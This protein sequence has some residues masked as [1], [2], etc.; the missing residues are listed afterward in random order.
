M[1]HDPAVEQ[2]RRELFRA[3]QDDEEISG[4]NVVPSKDPRGGVYIP[5]REFARLGGSAPSI[6]PG[7]RSRTEIA[8]LVLLKPSLHRRPHKWTFEW[9]GVPLSAKV[10]DAAFM[11]TTRRRGFLFGYG[12]ALEVEISYHQDFDESTGLYKNDNTSFVITRVIRHIPSQ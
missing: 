10:N 3:V 11:E 12:D 8:T 1:K 4:I 7:R 5:R 2:S 6:T 9:N